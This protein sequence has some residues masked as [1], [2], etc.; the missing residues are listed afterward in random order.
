MLR[1]VIKYGGLVLVIIGIIIVMSNLFTSDDT[2]K[3]SSSSGQLESNSAYS[4]KISLLD[5]ETEAFVTGANLVVKDKDGQ[6]VSGWTTDNGVHLITGL[7]NG[8][9]TLTEESAPSGYHLNE[10][11]V[12]FKVKNKDQEVVMYNF[13]MTEEELNNASSSDG[14]SASNEVGVENTLSEKSIVTSII[15]MICIVSGVFLMIKSKLNFQQEV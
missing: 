4:V 8:T 2:W 6:V 15:A 11:G 9:Y 12:T 3:G 7:K 13:S 14:S 5:K 10:D 1:N